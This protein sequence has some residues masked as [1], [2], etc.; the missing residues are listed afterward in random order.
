M[1]AFSLLLEPGVHLTSSSVVGVVY[2]PVEEGPTRRNL[3]GTLE[4][5]ELYSTHI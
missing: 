4:L 3:L 5:K 2:F 1:C